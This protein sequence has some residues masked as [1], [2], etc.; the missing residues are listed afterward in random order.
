[1]ANQPPLRRHEIHLKVVTNVHTRMR[2]NLL[3]FYLN[4]TSENI[5]IRVTDTLA[6]RK[7]KSYLD[8]I[9]PSPCHEVRYPRAK[10]SQEIFIFILF[11]KV[12]MQC[13]SMATRPCLIYDPQKASF[14]QLADTKISSGFIISSSNLESLLEHLVVW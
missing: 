9:L 11:L 8:I 1:M 12:F 14:R 7:R 6:R 10:I 4:A 3:F 13:S 5:C 2:T